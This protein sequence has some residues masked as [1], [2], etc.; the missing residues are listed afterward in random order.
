MNNKKVWSVFVGLTLTLATLFTAI[1]D[2]KANTSF[3]QGFDV[4]LARMSK[5]DNG[6]C[7][8]IFGSGKV[9]VGNAWVKGGWSDL[10]F[11]NVEVWITGTIP[12]GCSAPTGIQGFTT[13]YLLSTGAYTAGTIKGA[14]LSFFNFI[15]MSCAYHSIIFDTNINGVC[16]WKGM[17]SCEWRSTL[18][19]AYEYQSEYE[20]FSTSYFT[21]LN[22]SNNLFGA[23]RNVAVEGKYQIGVGSTVLTPNCELYYFYQY[24]DGSTIRRVYLNQTGGANTALSTSTTATPIYSKTKIEAN[25]IV[26]AGT[27]DKVTGRVYYVR[28]D[29][30]CDG[31]FN[32]GYDIEIPAL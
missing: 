28:V 32:S 9:G 30:S 12:A 11:S 15:P 2:A 5:V 13:P 20:T 27:V 19:S 26:L 16:D 8:S 14:V 3:A 18:A 4:T 31:V 6:T 10:S 24:W 22:G 29:Y 23:K 25:K 7:H 1:G 21:K 17:E